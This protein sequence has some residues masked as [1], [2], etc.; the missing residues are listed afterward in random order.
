MNLN[1][2]PVKENKEK[3]DHDGHNY[4]LRPEDQGVVQNN[5]RNIRPKRGA[6]M[7]YKQHKK[8]N[9]KQLVFKNNS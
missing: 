1:F 2:E 8:P 3:Y 6:K 5:L 9:V 7:L 4:K